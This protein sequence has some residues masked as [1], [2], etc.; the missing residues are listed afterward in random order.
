M[1]TTH[2]SDRCRHGSSTH[3]TQ[4][5]PLHPSDRC[6]H[7]FSTHPT[8]PP[9]PLTSRKF[10]LKAYKAENS[11]MLLL[12]YQPNIICNILREGVKKTRLFWGHVFFQGRG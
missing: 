6:R 5:P 4:P 8:Q 9:P 11:H 3:L 1:A 7:G 2:P 10:N 12:V